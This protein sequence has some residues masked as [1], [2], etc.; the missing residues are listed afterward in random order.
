MRF[1]LDLTDWREDGIDLL[2]NFT[3][4]E[5]VSQGKQSDKVQMIIKNPNL[6]ISAETGEILQSQFQVIENKSFPRQL[7]KGVV[8]EEVVSDA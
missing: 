6:F 8:E 1:S 4:P 5:I 2:I 7:P 3:N